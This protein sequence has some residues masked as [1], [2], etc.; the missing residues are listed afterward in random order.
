V[1][2]NVLVGHRDEGRLRSPLEPKDQSARDDYAADGTT[3]KDDLA[4][5]AVPRIPLRILTAQSTCGTEMATPD[6]RVFAVATAALVAQMIVPISPIEM[7]E[8]VR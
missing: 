6:G 5:S 3:E 4:H 7:P 1:V 2:H 8:R